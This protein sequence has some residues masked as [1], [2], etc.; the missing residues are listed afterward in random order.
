MKGVSERPS[1]VD[2]S[3]IDI[4]E[5]HWETKPVLIVR[6]SSLNSFTALIVLMKKKKTSVLIMDTIQ[7]TNNTC[8]YWTAQI[9]RLVSGFVV[10][11]AQRSLFLW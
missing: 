10:R 11:R 5:L 6:Q 9:R 2:L 1:V 8:A 7:A 3:T 4:F